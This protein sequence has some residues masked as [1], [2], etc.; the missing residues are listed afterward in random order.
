MIRYNLQNE[1]SSHMG[2]LLQKI[3]QSGFYILRDEV[4]KLKI[5]FYYNRIYS[6]SDALFNE[7]NSDEINYNG[8]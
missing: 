7:I 4:H 5:F 8:R 6:C 3:L 1:Y 2:A